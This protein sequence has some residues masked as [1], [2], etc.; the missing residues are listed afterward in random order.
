MASVWVPATF[1]AVVLLL[2]G[3]CYASSSG[4]W[5]YDSLICGPDTWSSQG[6]CNGKRQ[7]PIDI[8]TS[9]VRHNP[10][11]GA[12]TLSGYNDTKKLLEMKNTGKTVD[13]ELGE[14]L[15]L[16]G[17]GLPA[18]Y[19][20]KAFHLHWGDGVHKPG[21]EHY[22]NGERYSMELHI[23][24]TKNNTSLSEALKDPQGIAV[25]AFFVQGYE[26]AQGKTAEAWESFKKKLKEV[27]EK[28]EETKFDG[29]F[30]LQDLLGRPEL[31]RYYRYPG[32]LT[33]PGCDEVVLWTIFADPILV[34]ED[35]VHAFPNEL[36][37]TDSSTGPH[38][39]NNYRPLQNIG[40]RKVESSAALKHK[41]A[42]SIA[43][44]PVG[45]LLFI[46]VATLASFLPA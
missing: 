46:S 24:H 15:Q 43:S 40:D 31:D 33:T 21:S 20:A 26:K 25:L 30:S 5:C 45:L 28:G 37:S 23:V 27:E 3:G 39:E 14:G 17:P 16:S 34:S 29:S 12:V 22:I 10:K 32:S 19:T 1:T 38:I 18:T 6:H 13:I 36:H 2:S 44:P 11:L 35:V 42:A 9:S 8:V 4:S 41:S 7:S